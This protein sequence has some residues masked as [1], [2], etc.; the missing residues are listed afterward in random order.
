M[1]PMKTVIA[2]GRLVHPAPALAVTL[3]SA[4]LGLI[5]LDRS[6][7]AVTDRL[8]LTVLS[9]AGSQVFTGATN[10]LADRELDR[11]AGRE[12]KPLVAG[13]L[14]ASAALWLASAGLAV[15]LVASLWLGWAPLALGA[16][17]SA[18]AAAYNLALSRTPYSFVPYLISF[19]LLP[20]W[21][22]AGVGVDPGR[23]LIAVP[24]AGSFAVAAHLANTLRDFDIDAAA[25]SRSLAQVLG[26]ANARAMALTC[27]FIAGG[28]LAVTLLIA[29]EPTPASLLMAAAGLAAVAF[30]ARSE[31]ALWYALLVAAVCWTAAWALAAG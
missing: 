28:G 3:L 19:G 30:G 9:V 15:Q 1:R 29:G 10:D 11:A 4:V 12:E 25:E 22:A 26:R 8:W 24:L 5:L 6:G 27:A 17:A 20:P 18:S 16:V 13:D 21:I 2:A 23:V 7:Q 14:S 31:R